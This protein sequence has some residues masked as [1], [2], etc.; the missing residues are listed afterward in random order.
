[1]K[2]VFNKITGKYEFMHPSTVDALLIKDKVIVLED[3]ATEKVLILKDVHIDKFRFRQGTEVNILTVDAHKW[4]DH[5]F[6]KIIKKS[7][8]LDNKIEKQELLNKEAVVNE[9]KEIAPPKPKAK[10]KPK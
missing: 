1:M 7:K 10:A 5:G 4:Q 3:N 8:E 2:Q 6:V 9:I